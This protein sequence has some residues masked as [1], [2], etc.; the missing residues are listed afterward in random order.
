MSGLD[1]PMKSSAL[2]ELQQSFFQHLLDSP[3]NIANHIQSTVDRSAEQRLH[4]YASGYRLRLKEAISTDFDRLYSYMGDEMFE[5]LMDVYIDKYQSQHTSLRYYSQHMIDL[6]GQHP[7]FSNYPEL[8]EIAG[9]EQAFNFSF[10]AVDCTTMSI[11]KIAD[12]PPEAWESLT[13][14]FHA[15]LQILSLQNNSFSI[16]KALSENQVP[17]ES[18]QDS[19]TWIIWR[20][21][22]VSRY[23]ALSEPEAHVLRLAMNG[24]NFGEMCEAMFD[25]V[26]EQRAATEMIS[27]L[28]AWIMEKMVCRLC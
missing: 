27:F 22:L 11:Q 16:W 15:S 17:P 13:L 3:S 14:T 6:L 8:L 12:I 1:S 26:D 23:R 5:L 19:T 20:N 4:I 2:R 25:Y 21:D 28:Q 10:D 7:A 9:I 24:A 18:T